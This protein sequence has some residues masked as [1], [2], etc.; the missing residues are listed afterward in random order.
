[1]FE[2]EIAEYEA[3]LKEYQEKISGRPASE[4][5][6]EFNGMKKE[7]AQKREMN[8]EKSIDYIG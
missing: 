7:L 5:M 3:C 6:K 2:K 4:D 8:E 1:M